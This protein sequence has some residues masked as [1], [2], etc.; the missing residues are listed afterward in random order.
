[1]NKNWHDERETAYQVC[2]KRELFFSIWNW[3]CWVEIALACDFLLLIC[4]SLCSIGSLSCGLFILQNE[5]S[6]YEYISGS[7]VVVPEP[8]RECACAS[9]LSRKNAAT[10]GR[11]NRV[12][13]APMPTD[14]TDCYRPSDSFYMSRCDRLITMEFVA[15]LNPSPLLSS[16]L[17]L[18]TRTIFS[19][20]HFKFRFTFAAKTDVFP[21]Q[22]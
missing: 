20:A 4:D 11:L 5:P 6:R 16:N 3:N 9:F 18:R 8:V 14:Q 15:Q 17:H 7:S 19:N 21:T 1:M 2:S 22:L 10:A 13:I 12:L